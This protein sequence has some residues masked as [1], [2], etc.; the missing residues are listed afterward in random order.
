MSMVESSYTREDVPS[1]RAYFGKLPVDTIFVNPLLNLSDGSPLAGEKDPE[2]LK[3]SGV[4]TAVCRMPW[5]N[6]AIGWDGR[7]SPCIVDYNESHCVGDANTESLLDIW[8]N[9][10]YRRFRRCHLDG[11]MDWI[12]AQGPLCANCNI[13]HD[14]DYAEYD[15][16][17]MTDYATNY[18]MR[19]SVVH[20][21]EQK[22]KD[23][24]SDPTTQ[25]EHAFCL[26]ELARV[27]AILARGEGLKP[28]EPS[29]AKGVDLRATAILGAPGKASRG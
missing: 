12:E 6:M 29:V 10:G 26:E 18:I 24:A 27:E 8:N 19:Q 2:E 21:L 13:P 17:R 11:D 3:K 4:K 1:Y 25:P 14:P 28:A 5:M 22:E 15:L 16:L 7:I 9:M 20:L 23:D